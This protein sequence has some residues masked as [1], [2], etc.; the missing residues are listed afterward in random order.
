[1]SNTNTFN[2]PDLFR[3]LE[4]WLQVVQHMLR[5]G[6]VPRGVDEN[7]YIRLHRDLLDQVRPDHEGEALK[8]DSLRHSL[9]HAVRP[10]VN[11]DSLTHCDKKI[12]RMLEQEVS[13]IRDSLM[14]RHHW[15]S[16]TFFGVAA[17]SITALIA[18]ALIGS[19]NEAVTTQL[20]Q[21]WEYPRD[22]WAQLWFGVAQSSMNQRLI[23]LAGTI[24]L[25]GMFFL[26]DARRF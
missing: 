16:K 10:W 4:Q 13:R 5:R 12:L 23:V 2:N 22:L 24:V 21:L 3:N 18:V 6:R 8:A 17:V 25:L 14:P 7:T 1:M 15:Q 26:R 19:G 20:H 11:L 9:Y